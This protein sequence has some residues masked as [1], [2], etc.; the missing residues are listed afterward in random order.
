MTRHAS[1]MTGVTT[2][3]ITIRNDSVDTDARSF[4]AVI[5]N[6]RPVLVRDV[7]VW[8][9]IDEVLVASGVSFGGDGVV[10]LDS[11]ARFSTADVLGSFGDIRTEGDRVMARGTMVKDNAR[12]DDAFNK[13]AQGHLTDVSV[14]YR[15]NNYVD[16]P[17]GETQTING[18]TYTAGPRVLRVTTDWTLR[19]V[20]LVPI[21]ADEMAKIRQDAGLDRSNPTEN[22]TMN[23]KQRQYLESIGLRSDAS[24]AFAASYVDNLDDQ[25]RAEY[26]RM[27]V[28]NVAV[29]EDAVANE[30]V[31]PTAAGTQR[32]AAPVATGNGSATAATPPVDVEAAR[33]RAVADERRRVSDIEALTGPDV[34]EELVTQARSD[35]WPADRAAREF[36]RHI[37]DNRT[38]PVNRSAP[39]MISREHARDCSTDALGQALLMRC[40]LHAIP[41]GLSDQERSRLTR[42]SEQGQRYTGYSLVEMCREALRLDDVRAPH[43]R[44]E[45][46][47]AAVSTASMA[48][49]FTSSVNARLMMS[50]DQTPDTTAGWVR[51]VDVP[52]FKTNERILPG[53]EDDLE[54]LA[55]G[56]EAKDMTLSDLKEEYKVFRYA[57]KFVIDE[58]DIIDDRL[59]A[60][61]D[62]PMR[63][64]AAA[65][66]IRPDLVYYILM[67]NGTLG[68]DSVALFHA[69]THGNLR[70][71]AALSAT[72]LEAAR[73]D[74]LIQQQDGVNLNITP[75]FLI[76]PAV[77]EVTAASIVKS[78]TLIT[79]SD[80]VRGDFNPLSAMNWNVITDSR[81]DN[82]V[83]DPVTKVAA[84]G[85]ANNWFLAADPNMANSIEVGYLQGTSRKPMLRSFV[86]SQG[87]YGIGWDIKLDIGAKALDY[88][89]LHRNEG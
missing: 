54:R 47:R 4:N 78:M 89:G 38:E 19:E 3:S 84:A 8:R 7:E 27:A 64:G 36:L 6:E 42:A 50:Y 66:R 18:K 44:D 14:G 69:A 28:A 81:L 31:T 76:V 49:I 51:E 16:I 67:S 86:L 26:D 59:N 22:V 87:R 71:G 25:Q 39:G 58:Q 53:K 88:R 60:L 48:N 29:T 72:T 13:I 24:T 1:R 74:M 43:G 56:D 62:T 12:A 80:I 85:D 11:H 83:T 33:Q 23:K 15:A 41:D 5:S 55:R 63:L 30:P 57:K 10:M 75:K 73:S 79:G 2:R 32:D 17:A 46:I 37:N 35:G 68:A 40:G 52:D 21:G 77:L 20:S 70:T 45:M 34:P 82:G 61:L 9:L 65:K